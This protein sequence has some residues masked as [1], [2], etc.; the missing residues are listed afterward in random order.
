MIDDSD[1]FAVNPYRMMSEEQTVAM[2]EHMELDELLLCVG[3]YLLTATKGEQGVS[4]NETRAELS[5]LCPHELAVKCF[6]FTDQLVIKAQL[7]QRSN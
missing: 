6:K 7:N 2:F 5:N 1:V 4:V 3:T